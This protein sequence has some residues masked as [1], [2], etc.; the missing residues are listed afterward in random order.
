[1]ATKSQ[2]RDA[3]ETADR[4]VMDPAVMAS[5]ASIILSWYEY[6]VQGNRE[7]GIFIGLWPPTFLAFASYFEQTR[8]SQML[9]HAVGTGSVMESVEQLIRNR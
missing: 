7:M 4:T 3:M 1:M 8:I 5:V 2:Q 9:D 6:F